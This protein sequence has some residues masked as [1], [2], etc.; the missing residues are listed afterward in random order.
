MH[1]LVIRGGTIVDGTG[2]K[3]YSGD[4]A[5][6][7]GIITQVGGKAGLSRRELAAEG[8]LVTPGFVDIHTHYDG[9]ATWDPYLGPSG[10]HGVTTIVMGNCGVG[11][12]PARKDRHDWLIQLMEGVEDIPGS[13]LTEGMTW[14]WE[15]FPEYLDALERFPRAVD[16]GTQVPHGAVRAFVMGG[17]GAA[18]EEATEDDIAAMAAIVEEGL[19]AGA[20]GFSSSRTMLHRAKDGEP[21]PGT[22]AGHE[23]LIGIG[24]ACGRAGHGVFEIST[25][26]AIGGMHGRFKD[27]ISWMSNLSKET[28]LPVSF[29]LAQAAHRPDEWRDILRWMDEAVLT[30]ANLRA[31][32]AT[33][34]AGMLLNFD[35]EMHPFKGHPTYKSIANVPFEER[36]SLL[37]RPDIRKRLA[38]ESTSVTGKFDTFFV[39]HFDNMYPLGDPPDYEPTP[40]RSIAGIAQREGR[41][42]QEVLLE[43]MLKNDGKDFVYY[44]IINYAEKS[45]GPIREMLVHPR[46]LLSLSD[47]GAHCGVICDASSPSYMLTHWVRDRERGERLSLEYAVKLQTSETANAYGLKDRGLLAPGMRADLNIIDFENLRLHAPEAVHDLPASGRRL[48]Q[49]VDGY[50]ATIQS[51]QVTYENGSATGLLPGKLI[52]GPQGL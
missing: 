45:F 22:F 34:P 32:V 20:L 24:R 12:A 49:K 35:N 30:G 25:D 29:I 52:R 31:Q 10:W 13:A 17:R 15:T 21:V 27:D 39:Q 50:K 2:T 23:E 38:E 41:L 5:I 1:D 43:A 26:F 11:F 42:P 14:D 28:G 40:D 48:V 3:S 4:I 33:R 37:K 51:G 18:N 7:N 16:V 8:L 19:R 9:Q 46:T 44:P 36:L 6:E 47:G